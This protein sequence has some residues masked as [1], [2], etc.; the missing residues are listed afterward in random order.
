MVI[1]T[2]LFIEHI[3]AKN[4]LNTTLYL[5]PESSEL[6][7]SAVSLY[8][9]Y[10]GA[11]TPDKENDIRTITED[12]QVLPL[13]NFVAIKAARLYHSLKQQNKLIEFRDIFIAATCIVNDM[14]LATLN[15]KHFQR[16]NELE[17][18]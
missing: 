9:L 16:I 6:F 13:N 1:D 2:G 12:L 11:A 10:M 18:I 4:K 17:L 14:P 8:E 7:I 3:R 5:L 15:K